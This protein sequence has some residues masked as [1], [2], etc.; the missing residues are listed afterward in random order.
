MPMEGNGQR[1]E[2]RL[3]QCELYALL[4]SLSLAALKE[5]YRTAL[6]IQAVGVTD[7]ETSWEDERHKKRRFGEES[8]SRRVIG[9]WAGACPALVAWRTGG[10]SARF[11]VAVQRV[12]DRIGMCGLIRAKTQQG[13]EVRGSIP[14]SPTVFRVF[15]R[16]VYHQAGPPAC[17]PSALTR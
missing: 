11:P 2:A 6:Y 16:I 17:Q 15:P 3:D 1:S 13:V 7:T 8:A 14:L 12:L 9:N 4:N 10:E 5:L